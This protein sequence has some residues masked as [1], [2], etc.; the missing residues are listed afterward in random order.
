LQIEAAIASKIF[1]AKTS[2]NMLKV[3]IFL[4]ILY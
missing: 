4:Y 3:F 2:S 1:S